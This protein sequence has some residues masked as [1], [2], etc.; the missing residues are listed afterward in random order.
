MHVSV[1]F[2]VSRRT[3][4]SFLFGTGFHERI[5]E[6]LVETGPL[7]FLIRFGGHDEREPKRVTSI[8]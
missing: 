3:Y 6:R 5:D 4:G 1:T 8:G 2:S 7:N